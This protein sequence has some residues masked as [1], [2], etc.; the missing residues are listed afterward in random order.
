MV[1]GRRVLC[2]SL[3]DTKDGPVST[4][5]RALAWYGVHDRGVDPITRNGAG[6]GPIV[7]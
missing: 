7:A 3:P 2:L 5:L 6:R 4:W 1:G